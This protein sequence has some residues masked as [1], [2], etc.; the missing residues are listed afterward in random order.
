MTAV[1]PKTLDFN[2]HTNDLKLSEQ[3]L[4]KILSHICFLIQFNK[5]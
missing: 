2:A 4:I 3:E 1:T 5:L